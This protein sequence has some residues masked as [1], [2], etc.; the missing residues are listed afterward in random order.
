MEPKDYW[1][2]AI[3]MVLAALVPIVVTYGLLTQETA[4]LWV[5]L[6]MALAA[7]IVPVVITQTA[8]NWTKQRA[9]IEVA[10]LTSHQ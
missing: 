5:A 2:N 1:M 7:V 8:Q 4:E 10:R 9:V 6:I 3:S